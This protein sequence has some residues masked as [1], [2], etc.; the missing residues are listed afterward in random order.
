MNAEY[1]KWMSHPNMTEVMRTQG[2][3]MTEEERYD[4][5]YTGLSFGTAGLRGINGIGPNRMNEYTVCQC[6]YGIGL[7]LLELASQTGL[8]PAAAIGY[9][10]RNRAEEFARLTA[11][12]LCGMG[13]HVRMLPGSRPTP[14]VSNLILREEGLLGGVCITASHNPPEYSGIKVFNSLGAQVDDRQ[15]E[16]I[17][18]HMAQHDP[19]ECLPEHGFDHFT[20]AGMITILDFKS[21]E[22]YIHQVLE[23]S[24]FCGD[25]HAAG[26]LSIVYTP[27][28]GVGGMFVPDLL[29]RSGFETVYTVSEQMKPCGDFPTVANPNPESLQSFDC[30]LA[31]ARQKNVDLILSNDPDADRLGVMCRGGED[32]IY[33]TGNQVGALLTDYL[34]QMRGGEGKCLIQTIVTGS[35]SK[36]VAISY[37]AAVH[38]TF[39]G[40]RNIAVKYAQLE[41]PCI[42]AYEEAIGYMIGNHVRDK[43]GLTAAVTVAQMAAWHKAKGHTLGEALEELWR[44]HGYY[45]DETVSIAFPGAK[46]AARMEG[47]MQQLRDSGPPADLGPIIKSVDYL[48]GIVKKID[49]TSTSDLRGSNVLSYKFGISGGNYVKLIVRPSGTEPKIKLYITVRCE[50]KEEGEALLREYTRR[51]LREYSPAT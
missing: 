5:F 47:I 9:D 2:S 32:Y 35:L 18:A 19:L 26:E 50:K 7:W 4:S 45:L 44:R 51:L 36:A 39:T 3:G 31:L 17:S 11:C 10:A 42:M 12:V 20:S 34:C 22:K 15:V 49:G 25:P 8:S 40:F 24:V 13:I 6:A 33:L 14:Q 29:S 28:H 16:V 1:D 27:L 38:A 23:N 30:A 46:G 37:G 21:D 48:T 41:S 43:D